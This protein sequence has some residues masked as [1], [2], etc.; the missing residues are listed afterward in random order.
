MFRLSDE[1]EE[2]PV[3]TDDIADIIQSIEHDEEIVSG[4]SH[5]LNLPPEIRLLIYDF[6][7]EGS[8]LEVISDHLSNVFVYWRNEEPDA[9]NVLLVNK[10]IRFEAM[11]VLTRKTST[12]SMT[13]T[14]TNSLNKV[15]TFPMPDQ[16]K[17]AITRIEYENCHPGARVFLPMFP[18]LRFIGI[19]SKTFHIEE[20]KRP[21]EPASFEV[22]STMILGKVRKNKKLTFRKS[23]AWV[24]DAPLVK[25]ILKVL[26]MNR[27]KNYWTSGWVSDKRLNLSLL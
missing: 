22:L 27:R 12:L 9:T 20:N 16:W 24:S 14:Y 26:V 15:L 11:Q 10:L 4:Y 17:M 7:F 25:V 8:R 19:G 21:S 23:R 6:L 18:N 5:Y 2:G 13:S 3:R 1:D